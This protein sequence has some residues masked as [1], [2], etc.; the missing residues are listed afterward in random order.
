MVTS[1]AFHSVCVCVRAR[2]RVCTESRVCVC[3][4]SGG[5]HVQSSMVFCTD[6][7]GLDV[8]NLLQTELMLMQTSS[9]PMIDLFKL[10]MVPS[11]P[12]I[13]LSKPITA[14]SN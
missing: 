6:S 11:V 1:I 9:K 4:S 14:L 5:K 12:I 13:V 8:S 3:S 7:H 2:A 10:I